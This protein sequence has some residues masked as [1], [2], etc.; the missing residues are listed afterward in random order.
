MKNLLLIS[1]VSAFLAS[2]AGAAITITWNKSGTVITGSIA[3]S[4]SSAELAYATS[5]TPNPVNVNQHSFD[6]STSVNNRNGDCDMY[7]FTTVLLTQVGGE[8]KMNSYNGNS[9]TGDSFG[10]YMSGTTMLL[11]LPSGYVPGAAISGTLT[12]NGQPAGYTLSQYFVFG[13]AFKLNGSPFITF[14]DG[15]SIP[16]PTSSLL[17]AASGLALCVR[18]RRGA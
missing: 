3:G 14:V 6:T 2:S 18:R 11:S 15:S 16:E 7:F 12:V 1:A 8:V 17:L 13:D 4:V 5:Q 10:Y 9:G